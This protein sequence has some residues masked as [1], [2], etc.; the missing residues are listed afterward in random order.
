MG[1][2]RTRQGPKLNPSRYTPESVFDRVTNGFRACLEGQFTEKERQAVV[3]FI[4]SKEFSNSVVG[5]RGS[6][7]A[8]NGAP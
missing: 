6:C 3:V 2:R 8:E 1:N 4:M 5:R 7:A